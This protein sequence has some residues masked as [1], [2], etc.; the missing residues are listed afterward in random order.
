MVSID[1]LDVDLLEML[2]RDARAGVLELASRLGISRNTVQS[3]LKRLEEGGLVAG[4]RPELDLA[5]IGIATQAF[6]GLEVQQGRLGP[7]V[8]ALIGIPQVLEIHA[9]AGR[10]DLLVR[11]ATETQAG[12]QQLIEQVV[13]IPGVVH[14]TTT[15]ALTTP[16]TFRAVPLLKDMTRNA[17]WGRS[18]PKD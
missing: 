2:A 9:T 14:S 12:L 3:R 1:R 18:T 4:Y 5:R 6:I 16:L 10:E 7:I 11:V 17:G 13:G 8:E 15:L